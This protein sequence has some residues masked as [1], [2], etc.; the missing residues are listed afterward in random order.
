M[1]LEEGASRFNLDN[2][3]VNSTNVLSSFWSSIP[4]KLANQI[5]FIIK[6]LMIAAALGIVYLAIVLFIKIF[7]VIFGSR[8]TRRLKKISGQLEEIIEILKMNKNQKME[9]RKKK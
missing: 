3:G 9:K 4:E 5:D 7:G 8:E 1:V 2:I 6:L